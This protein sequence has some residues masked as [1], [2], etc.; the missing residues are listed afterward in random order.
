MEVNVPTRRDRLYP[1]DLLRGL[2]IILMALDHANFH[3]AQQHSAGEY[4]GGFM[5]VYP[6]PVHFITR[7]ITHFSAPGFFFLM[8]AGMVLFFQSRTNKG[9][10]KKEIRMHFLIR[11]LVLIAFQLALNF[12]RIWSTGSTSAPLWYLGVLA[13]LGA[14]M[15]F[16]IP[17]LELKPIFLAY[18]AVLFFIIMEILTPDPRMWG[19]VFT[20][21]PG[22][23]L[24]FAGGQQD[25]WVNYPL[26]AWIEVILLGMMF[27]NWLQRK[28]EKAYKGGALLGSLFLV[29]FLVLRFMNGF[30]NIRSYQPGSWI[31]FLNLVKYPPSMTFN[32]FTIGINLILL[33]IISI[34]IPETIKPGNPLLVYG[35]TPLFSYLAHLV[36]YA[37]MGRVFVPQGSNLLIMYAL[38][39]LGLGILYLFSLW[40]G[41]Y[42]RT[43]T[44]NSWVRFL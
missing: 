9:W 1:L 30:G 43:Q 4:W 26:F 38:W 42:K 2:L 28:P 10:S 19:R 15:I 34:I 35:R 24:V 41:E 6:T 22:V 14:G 13:A 7:F 32:L 20:D 8:G 37:V 16:C 31:E 39:L 11:G 25:F 36:I 17:L 23:L 18:G 40:Y 3:I 27:G 29:A 21:I 5:P 12:G 33:W 44:E